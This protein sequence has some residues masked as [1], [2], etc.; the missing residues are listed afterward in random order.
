MFMRPTGAPIPALSCRSPAS[1][2]HFLEDVERALLEVKRYK[3]PTHYM[4]GIKLVWGALGQLR[5]MQART[6]ESNHASSPKR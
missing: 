2:P 1:P 5:H 6:F 3:F 4:Q